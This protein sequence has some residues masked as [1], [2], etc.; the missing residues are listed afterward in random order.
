MRAKSIHIQT[1]IYVD[2]VG[3]VIQRMISLKHQQDHKYSIEMFHISGIMIYF[4]PSIR[5]MQYSIGEDTA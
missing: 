2:L 4:I 1:G 5:T 3:S